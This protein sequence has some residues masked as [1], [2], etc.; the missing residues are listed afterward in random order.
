MLALKK[1]KAEVQQRL[2]VCK[3]Y[4]QQ[5]LT[6]KFRKAEHGTRICEILDLLSLQELGF[7]RKRI[8]SQ[9]MSRYLWINAE[10]GI[11]I[12]L[13]FTCNTTTK[14]KAAVPTLRLNVF[15]ITQDDARRHIVIQPLVDT[16]RAK[17][18]AKELATRYSTDYRDIHPGNTG[19]Y[20]GK[21]VFLDW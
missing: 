13:P 2:T 14:P 6:K 19:H 9:F 16:A 5:L 15:D 8:S 11:V 17:D 10:A 12:K 1:V 18:A 20:Q 7:T 4:C 21:A 3:P